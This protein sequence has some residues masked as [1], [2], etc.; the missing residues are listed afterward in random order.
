MS[1]DMINTDNSFQNQS[2]IQEARLA[3]FARLAKEGEIVGKREMPKAEKARMAQAAR[4]FEAMFLNMLLKEMKT[5]IKNLEGDKENLATFGAET[6]EGYNDMQFADEMSKVGKGMGI[7]E[8]IYKQ[9]TNGDDLQAI[10]KFDAT[11]YDFKSEFNNAINSE[12]IGGNFQDRLKNR[13]SQYDDVIM[14]ASKEF[15]IDPKLNNAVIAAESAGK[16]NAV[17]TAGAKGLM[18]IM[19]S[20]AGELGIENVFNP[21][22]NIYG[23][24]KYL[25]SMID[26]FGDTDLGLAAYNAGASNVDKYGGIPPFPETQSYVG[27]VKKYLELF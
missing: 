16:E 26:R 17:S 23:G 22:E 8:M 21:S 19:D 9:L 13:I 6:L 18:Q 1:I 3:K 4:G 24:A 25:K 15:G 5:G 27:K 2:A 20:T 10:T 12:N 11:T 7:A 14:N